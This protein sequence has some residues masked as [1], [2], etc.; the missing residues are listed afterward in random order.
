MCIF[1]PVY[2]RPRN[3]S[4]HKIRLGDPEVMVQSALQKSFITVS[5]PY[6]HPLKTQKDSKKKKKNR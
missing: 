2:E 3:R 5:Q 4:P 1:E 6:V